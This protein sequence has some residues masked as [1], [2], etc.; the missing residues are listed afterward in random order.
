MSILIG[1]LA[2][3]TP[4]G[5]GTP[6]AAESNATFT[7][8]AN[9]GAALKNP[10]RDVLP[11]VMV[12]RESVRGLAVGAPVDFRGIV[13][14]EV[15]AINLDIDPV[16]RQIVVPVSVNLYPERMRSRSLKS[17]ATT[18]KLL[19]LDSAKPGSQLQS[20]RGMVAR[21]LRAQLRTGNLLTGQLYIAADFFPD[22][23]K[24][25][26][27]VSKSPLEFPTIQSG[28][29]ELQAMIARIAEKIE[30]FPLEEVG[31]DLR[32]TLKSADKLMQRLDTELTPEAT[33]AMVEARKALASADRVLSNDSSL[34]Q[35]TRE[36]M[37]EIARAAQAFRNLADYLER[38]PEALISGKKEEQK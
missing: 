19:A 16:T 3:E 24:V 8:F 1:G 27:D 14:G 9:R 7:L 2:F 29:R 18:Q 10:E 4:H 17:V 33:A 5:A 11:V 15:V 37:R 36:M 28:L 22:A 30:K 20:V 26:L 34:Q 25:N 21:G 12:F 23:S 32:Q 35:N 6:P 31:A 38:H 13:V